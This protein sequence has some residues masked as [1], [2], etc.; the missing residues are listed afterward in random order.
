MYPQISAFLMGSL[1]S[2]M[3]SSGMAANTLVSY[4]PPQAPDPIVEEAL[5]IIGPDL[6]AASVLVLNQD[7]GETLYQKNSATEAPI[8]SITKLMTAM[9]ILDAHLSMEE[10]IKIS[11]LDV[12]RLR[13]SSSR[14]PVG[15]TLTRGEMLHLAL[16]AS[17]NRA[18]HAL[19][20][21]YPGGRAHFI[22]AMNN[23]ARSLDMRHTAF[24]DPTGLSSNN[25]STAE[26]LA[27][28]VQAASH[29]SQ[30][31]DITTTGSY[32]ISHPATIRV[33]KKNK[34]QWR[35]VVRHVEFRNTNRLVSD[36]NWDVRLS[37]TGFINEAGHCLVMQT[38]I[39]QQRVIIVLLDAYGSYGRLADARHIKTWLENGIADHSIA[40]AHMRGLPSTKVSVRN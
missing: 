29:Y 10:N 26:D 19:A 9:V 40:R 31:R 3:V 23:K 18:A 39:A 2:L 27:K 5:A 37:K 33:G 6:N 25:R 12:D 17:E 35:S 7:S 14:L 11:T 36:K 30:I 24:E 21:T 34:K 22:D 15:T 13:H 20:R 38:K 28:L 8:A 4:S 16:I 32:G 1:F